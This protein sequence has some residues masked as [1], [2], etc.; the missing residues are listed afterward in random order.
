MATG[1]EV[2]FLAVGDGSPGDAIALRYGNL[3]GSRDEQTVVVIDGGYRADGDRVVEH[4][5]TH[6]GTGRVDY[7]ISTH[8][9]RD[10]INGLRAV[11]EK[12]DVSMLLMHKP[13]SHTAFQW[14]KT[15]FAHGSL[16]EFVAKSLDESD[17]LQGLAERRGVHVVE[18]FEGWQSQDGALRVLGPSR[19]YYEAVLE[20][21]RSSG[22]AALPGTM[23]AREAS[24]AHAIEKA[25]GT[26]L[27]F[28]TDLEDAVTEH[29]SERSVVEPSNSSSVV[30]LLE[31]AGKRLLFTGDAGEE[32]LRP[33]AGQLRREGVLER[34]LNFVQIPHHGSRKNVTPSLLNELLGG[35]TD[36]HRGTAF[37]SVP[38]RNPK[39]QFPS[40]QV[41]NAFIRRGYRVVATAGS[42]KRHFRNATPRGWG[43]AAEVEFEPVVEVFYD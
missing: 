16:D 12:L 20:E 35:F 15:A 18:P 7:V 24:L 6:Y 9:D 38:A 43:K 13:S 32:A 17:A 22:S 39:R 34:G 5:R 36:A 11:V 2:D 42:D 33:V 27:N 14:R 37:V 40:K 25:A 26:S 3:D 21:M 30:C 8:P 10:H 23:S 1:Y 4:I 29:L 19:R 31:V 28:E 41:T